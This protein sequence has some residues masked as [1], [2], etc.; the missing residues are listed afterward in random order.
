MTTYPD[1]LSEPPA[2]SIGLPAAPSSTRE[3]LLNQ[4]PTN[5]MQAGRYS[6]W[7]KNNIW[8]SLL[9]NSS[10]R[11]VHDAV[12]FSSGTD[13]GFQSGSVDWREE[14][15]VDNRHPFVCLTFYFS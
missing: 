12:L 6:S 10:V 3:L 2:G 9:V 8:V 14:Y 7:Y 11:A 4:G 1:C 5:K 15:L 13:V